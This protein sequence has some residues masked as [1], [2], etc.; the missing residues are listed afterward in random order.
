M[1]DS[2]MKFGAHRVDYFY[3][4]LDENKKA[5]GFYIRAEISPNEIYCR[6]AKRQLYTGLSIIQSK[7]EMKNLMGIY[8]DVDSLNNLYRPAYQQLKDDLR[9]GLFKRLFV[10]DEKALVGSL[11][12]DKDVYE[13]Y[14]LVGGFEILTCKDGDCV[15]V[16]LFSKGFPLAV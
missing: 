15:P 3:P 6:E 2:M 11:L 4:R 10:L 16:D 13:L 8:L 1:L 14:T 5:F 7:H 12:A 9:N